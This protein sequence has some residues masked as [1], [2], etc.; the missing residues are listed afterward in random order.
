MSAKYKRSDAEKFETL[1]RMVGKWR[2]KAG[3]TV[4]EVLIA[5]RYE[6]RDNNEFTDACDDAELAVSQYNEMKANE[7]G[8]AP[9]EDTELLDGIAQGFKYGSFVKAPASAQ[10]IIRNLAAAKLAAKGYTK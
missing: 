5:L 3:L 8:N 10:Q 9:K 7:E 2:V 4:P 6:L 1:V